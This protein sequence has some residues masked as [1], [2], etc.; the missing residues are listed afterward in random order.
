[1]VVVFWRRSPG[2]RARKHVC[3]QGRKQSFWE[4]FCVRSL[5]LWGVSVR[6]PSRNSLRDV[7]WQGGLLARSLLEIFAQGLCTRTLLKIFWQDPCNCNVQMCTRPIP[8]EALFRFLG[9]ISLGELYKVDSCRKC[10]RVIWH[11]V[12]NYRVEAS[13]RLPFRKCC[14]TDRRWI[15]SP[16]TVHTSRIGL[17]VL[18][19]L[20]PQ[21][22]LLL[23]GHVS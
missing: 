19:I 15:W 13:T 22:S 9:K 1:M 20:L 17:D 6:D 2:L 5:R 7:S 16:K 18:E 23:M 12:T 3:F 14:W 10:V 8:S 11:Q 21:S 4:I